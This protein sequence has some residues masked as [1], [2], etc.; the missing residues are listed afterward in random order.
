MLS[1]S[2]GS[3]CRWEEGLRGR[4]H[5]FSTQLVPEVLCTGNRDLISTGLGPKTAFPNGIQVEF[6]R[7]VF[8][9]SYSSFFSFLSS[10]V[11]PSSPP[12]LIP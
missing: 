10:F 4:A 9:L 5:T 11:S 7:Q 3:V 6:T 12:V 8:S 1:T 2:L